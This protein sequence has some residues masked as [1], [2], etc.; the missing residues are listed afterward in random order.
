MKSDLIREKRSSIR[1]RRRIH[2]KLSSRFASGVGGEAHQSTG[3]VIAI[4]RVFMCAGLI[5]ESGCRVD[6]M[7]RG[8]GFPLKPASHASG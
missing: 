7:S 1:N 3:R 4:G 6:G 2:S 8:R 5:L